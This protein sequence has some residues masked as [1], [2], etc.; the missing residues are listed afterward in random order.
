M[1][2]VAPTHRLHKDVHNPLR[3]LENSAA[4]ERRRWKEEV[5]RIGAAQRGAEG[6]HV[7]DTA[8]GD[9]GAALLP[10]LPFARVPH[11]DAHFVLLV[12]QLLRVARL[13]AIALELDAVDLNQLARSAVASLAPWAIPQRRTVAFVGT[14]AP[15]WIRANASAVEDAIRNL[16]ENGVL[17]TPVEGEVTVSVHLEGRVCVADQGCGVAAEDRERIFDRFWRGND[18]KTEGAG[19]GL[20]IVREIMNAHG[21]AVKVEDNPG[22]GAVFSLSFQLTPQL[23]GKPRSSI[24]DQMV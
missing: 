14:R 24:S 10:A 12:E 17:H 9:F 21:G 1:L 2:Q 22:G 18:H 6:V 4:R 7:L 13:D 3:A 16:V 19:L 5:G 15:V 8:H 20:A 23:A 11:E